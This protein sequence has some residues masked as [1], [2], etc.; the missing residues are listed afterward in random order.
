M[1]VALKGELLEEEEEEY[2]K[3]LR[4]KTTVHGGIETEVKSRINDV[5]KVLGL[6]KKVFSCR[7][8]VMN[9]KRR[10]YERVAVPTGNM[11]V[12]EKTN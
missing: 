3:Y 4:S 6:M 2:L 7:S 1:N 11:A 8:I 10:L 12:A 9:V 5:G